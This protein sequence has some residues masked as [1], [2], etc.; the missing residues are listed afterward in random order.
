HRTLVPW[1]TARCG[2]S[3]RKQTEFTCRRFSAAGDP[4]FLVSSGLEG[5]SVPDYY[6]GRYPQGPNL[7]LAA[8]T[9]F[10]EGHPEAFE[11]NLKTEALTNRPNNYDVTERIA[12]FYVKNTIQ[13]GAL[14]VEAAGRGADT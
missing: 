8:A 7:S 5:F 13:L 6:F 1:I 11:E 10:F 4:A 2:L 12:A 9:R 3:T 14:H